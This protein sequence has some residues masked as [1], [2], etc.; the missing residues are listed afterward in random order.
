MFIN[1]INLYKKCKHFDL[2]NNYVVQNTRVQ[3]YAKMLTTHYAI[4]F[5][6]FGIFNSLTSDL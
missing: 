2:S 4:Y 3:I 1:W 6:Y 5:L